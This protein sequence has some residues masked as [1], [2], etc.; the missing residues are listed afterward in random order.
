MPKKPINWSRC[1]IYKICCKDISVKEIYVGHTTH[2]I[3]RKTQHKYDCN[4]KKSPRHNLKLY[5]TIREHGG[6]N[7]WDIIIVENYNTCIDKL[8][9]RKRERHWYESLN[10]TLNVKVPGR[11]QKE[12][13][14]E[15]KEVRQ[16]Y[17]K[18]WQEEHKEELKEKKKEYNLK[19]RDRMKTYFTERYQR[20]KVKLL[21]QGK[22]RYQ[23]NKHIIAEKT[24]IYVSKNRDKIKKRCSIR[25]KCHKCNAEVLKY[26]LNRHQQS[27]SKCINFIIS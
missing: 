11:T 1:V 8:D 14:E 13:A 10:A 9:A 26:G 7:N 25:I 12:Y 15:H 19:N 23:R 16:E 21:E 5:K 18:Q 3:R 17:C 22:L 2:P 20:N 27:T 6:W 24:K 4:T